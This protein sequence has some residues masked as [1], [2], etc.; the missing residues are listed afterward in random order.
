[1]RS[2]WCSA[3]SYMQCLCA[4]CAAPLMWSASS[5]DDELTAARAW[6]SSIRAPR[7]AA[8]FA[9]CRIQFDRMHDW[10][11]NAANWF[12]MIPDGVVP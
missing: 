7:W 1:L 9:R 3:T 8:S 11:R 6:A 12:P 4:G 2:S 10:A 5:D